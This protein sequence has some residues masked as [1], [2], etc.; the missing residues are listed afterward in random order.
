M[1]I[2][3]HSGSL[4]VYMTP[5]L[6][7]DNSAL[8]R[9]HLL[10]HLHTLEGISNLALSPILALLHAHLTRIAVQTCVHIRLI[11]RCYMRDTTLRAPPTSP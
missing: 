8:T 9:L 11:S 6:G 4:Q 7:S 1:M 2:P 10:H 5:N 3:V